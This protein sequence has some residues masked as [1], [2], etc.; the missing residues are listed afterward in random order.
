MIHLHNFFKTYKTLLI[1]DIHTSKL[2]FREQ[3]L[4]GKIED[5][6]P[7]I[8]FL[9]GDYVSWDGDY[10]RA[11][12]FLSRLEAKFGIFGVLG[13]SDYQNSL[14]SCDLCHSFNQNTRV[15]PVRFLKNETIFLSAGK[16]RFAISGV[17]I[18]QKD[19]YDSRK[20]LKSNL[21]WPEILLSHKQIDLGTL[22]DRHIFVLSGDTHGGQLY[23]PSKIWQILF[24]TCKGKL[25][26]GL[27]EE[28]KRR[29]L[30]T[31]GLGTNR[32]PLRFICTPEIL[33]FKGI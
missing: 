3:L 8:I 2:G 24:G 33:L 18:F 21:G 19:K 1:S 25:R 28:G 4:L 11:F 12:D 31:S 27:M 23:L 6:S 26:A 5:I 16:T 15:L 14:K 13:D 32:I 22:P 7:D 20:I 29:L 30:V 9:V 10:E 17:E